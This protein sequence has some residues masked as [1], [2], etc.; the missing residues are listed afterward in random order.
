MNTYKCCYL[1]LLLSLS[2]FVFAPGFAQGT[3]GTQGSGTSATNYYF[4]KQNE[5]TLIVSVVGFVQRPGRYEVSSTV[6][7]VNLMALAG[8]PTADGAMNDVKLTRMTEIE[9]Q[10]RT[11][12]YHLN[13]E[14][15]SKITANELKLQPG[16]VLQVDRTG[17][18]A[19]RDTFTVVV[20]AAIVTGAV[21]QVIYATK[22]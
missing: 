19:F 22:R 5:L 3:L 20:G 12:E 11:R 13:L 2:L 7:V 14:E 4:A 9:G 10:I 8:G 18:S 6:D 1:F 15:I 17:W 16:D 21:A